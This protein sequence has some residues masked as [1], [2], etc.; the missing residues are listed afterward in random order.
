MQNVNEAPILAMPLAD[1]QANPGA[2][3]SYVVPNATFTDVDGSILV[4]TTRRPMALPYPWLSFNGVSR[5]F[6][7][8]PAAGDAGVFDLK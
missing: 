6:S 2:T 4:Y 7:G 1:Q 8:T 3:F 5:T